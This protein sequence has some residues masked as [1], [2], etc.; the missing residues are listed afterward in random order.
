MNQF[1]SQ[2]SIPGSSR[3]K[4]SKLF[5]RTVLSVAVGLLVGTAALAQKSEGTIYGTAKAGTAVTITSMDTG[6]KRQVQ[7]DA[8]GNFVLPLL[9]PGDYQLE[10][11]GVKKK[12]VVAIGSGTQVNL[13]APD[14]LE[15]V[16]VVARRERP[17][18][19][20][21]SQE[22]NTVFTAEQIQQ[23]P[24]SRAVNA[25]AQLAPGVVKPGVG[26]GD[27]PSFGGASVAENGYYINGFDVTNI[28]N[29]LAYADLPF[30]AVGQ[31]QIKTGGFGVE[32][33]RSMGG[34]VSLATK[35]GSNEWHGGVSLSYIPSSSVTAPDVMDR[36]PSRPGAYYLFNSP[37]RS[38]SFN[39]NLYLGGPLLPDKLF[40]F[41]L[42]E[43][44][45]RTADVY[46]QSSSYTATQNK[47]NGLVKLDF[48]PFDG[49]RIEY[50]YINNQKQTDYVD[51]TSA[52][53]FATTHDGDGGKSTMTEGGTVNILKY[54]GYLTDDLSFSALAGK[55]EYQNPMTTGYRTS[56][57]D[58]PY[59][60]A[61][62]LSS[63][64]CWT[65]PGYGSGYG[66]DASAPLVDMD[67]RDAFRVD[68]EY[69]VSKHRIK[70]GLDNQTFTSSQ[71]GGA[72]YSGGKYWRYYAPASTINGVAQPTAVPYA[73][74]RVYN[75]TSG[76]YKVLNTAQ[77]IEDNWNVTPQLM[78]YGGLRLESFN[79]MNGDGESFVKAQNLLA[80]RGGFSFDANGDSTLKVFGNYGRYYIP[81]A[82]NTNVR[83]TQGELYTHTFYTYANKDSRTL[84]P[85]G[86][87][88]VGPVVFVGGSDGSL[89]NAA[90]I[91]DQ[92]LKPMS[93]DELI[94]G[95]QQALAKGWT[96]GV[97]YT[98]RRVNDGMDDYCDHG[99]MAAYI[100]ANVDAGFRDNLPQCV[101]VNP[102]RPITIAVDL[103]NDGNLSNVSIPAASTGLATY[104]RE[105]NAL[106]F[107]LAKEFDGVWGGAASYTIS[108]SVGTAEGYV[109]STIQQVDAGVSQ[110]FDYGRF[111][112]GGYGPLA[113]QHQHAI[114]LYGTAS[115]TDK[116]RVGLNFSAISGR[117]TSRIGYVPCTDPTLAINGCNYGVASSY[118]HLDSSGK[119]VL[120]Q[121]G[122]QG[123]TEWVKQLDFQVA[124]T[125]KLGKAEKL[126][127]QLDVF[128]I[129]NGQ[130]VTDI[131]QTN[132]YSR[133]TTVVGQ[134]GQ[135]SMNYGLPMA[136]Q[137][138]RA[139]RISA[140]YEF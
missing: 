91:A 73:R 93:Q 65:P 130:A 94:I 49:Q 68:L 67:N 138:P 120:G 5:S 90:S 40:A 33:G 19:D 75:T 100:K 127:L 76:F 119:T 131:D 74:E 96:G 129:L 72:Y 63:L 47:P 106:E 31:Q 44:P 112:D 71:A 14:A 52:K 20:V 3:S 86:L 103:K 136:Y 18:I 83:M 8:A 134:V 1:S 21:S 77:Y 37:Q 43:S 64:G 117:P 80:P 50:T 126:T 16:S 48:L 24:V 99:Q 70:V 102:G 46:R 107:S 122:D 57:K 4:R 45:N 29:F 92:N 79:N 137:S 78:L 121:R 104:T 82:S 114:K 123:E 6:A 140:R 54:T 38:Q 34:I 55:V 42:L 15:S 125:E 53:Q 101:L 12:V 111:T 41:A 23:L 69:N 22:S 36:E 39:T 84:A 11:D 118:Y 132:D 2:M 124:Y 108:K 87:T 10:S 17:A 98:N 13:T 28:R 116:I 97:K 27:M 109:N 25:V 59:V 95:F 32:Y 115:V 139:I 88:Q 105:Y 9:S 62:D 133:A 56:G 81:V 26:Y 113:N 60:L 85:L 61:I 58:C 89:P 135:L 35:Q 51:Y 66:R 110:D 128:N 30:E 7:A